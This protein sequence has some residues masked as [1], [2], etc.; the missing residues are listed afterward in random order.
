M[1][2]I[3]RL[4]KNKNFITLFITDIFIVFISIYIS[5]LLRFDFN[6]LQEI[7]S[8][9]K[10]EYLLFIILIK[11]FCFRLFSLYRG[12]W[13]YTSVWD[14]INIIKANSLS[15]LLLIITV[16][17]TIG[18]EILSRSVFIIDYIFSFSN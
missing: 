3:S 12:M 15:S 2:K 16:Y 17:Y 5:V 8:F 6:L 11:I 7:K 10:L 13:R 4:I 1:R 9:F 18:F 14:M